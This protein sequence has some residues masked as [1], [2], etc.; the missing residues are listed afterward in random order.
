MNGSGSTCIPSNRES[1]AIEFEY[2]FEHERSTETAS[3]VDRA[4]AIL[5]GRDRD[6]AG[7]RQESIQ[8]FTS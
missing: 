7:G 2:S 6:A 3:G 4:G 1:A 8:T 5:A